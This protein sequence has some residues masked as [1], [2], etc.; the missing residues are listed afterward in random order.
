MK[1]VAA[2]FALAMSIA[3]ASISCLE[4]KPLRPTAAAAAAAAARGEGHARSQRANDIAAQVMMSLYC[5]ITRNN[6][7]NRKY[8]TLYFSHRS[9]NYLDVY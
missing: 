3:I 8:N 1:V 5:V 7:N 4:L 9:I 6:N 2:L